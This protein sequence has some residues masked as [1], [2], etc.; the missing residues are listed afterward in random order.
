MPLSQD[1]LLTAMMMLSK[2][3]SDMFTKPVN[4]SKF[5]AGIALKRSMCM[6]VVVDVEDMYVIDAEFGARSRAC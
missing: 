4:M 5:L 1:H 6:C 3:N 2:N